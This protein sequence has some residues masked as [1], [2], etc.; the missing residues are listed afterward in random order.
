MAGLLAP[1]QEAAALSGSAS[2]RFTVRVGSRKE[3]TG[4]SGQSGQATALG[5]PG[6]GRG[7]VSHLSHDDRRT[8]STSS[9]LAQAALHGAGGWGLTSRPQGCGYRLPPPGLPEV[10]RRRSRQPGG[11]SH[12]PQVLRP[13]DG[14][15]P[16]STWC[17][18]QSDGRNTHRC[19]PPGFC[20]YKDWLPDS[21]G[22]SNCAAGKGWPARPPR[23]GPRLS[24][25][26]PPPLLPRPFPQPQSSLQTSHFK[27]TGQPQPV[28]VSG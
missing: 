8:P 21:S 6:E 1:C 3:R 16:G 4:D 7:P 23:K 5:S 11:G 2:C 19:L 24:V 22:F 18:W 26:S 13:P 12:C 28:W 9:A 25:Q 15:P 20:C 10:G 14:W 17:Y 27:G